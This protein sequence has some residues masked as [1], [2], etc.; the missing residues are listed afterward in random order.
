MVHAKIVYIY[1]PLIR[2]GMSINPRMARGAAK[3]WAIVKREILEAVKRNQPAPK[4]QFIAAI[5]F[6]SGLT[7]KKVAQ[8]ISE[9]A[10]AGLVREDGQG[11]L[12]LEEAAE[13]LLGFK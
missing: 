12:Q 11:R 9:F 5:S 2:S 4:Q 8:Y 10:Q 6:S 1:T 7:L 13:S 3:Q